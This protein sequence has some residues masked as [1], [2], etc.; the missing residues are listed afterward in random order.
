[1][2]AFRGR[3]VTRDVYRSV[4][5]STRS[6]DCDLAWLVIFFAPGVLPAGGACFVPFLFELIGGPWQNP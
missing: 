2:Q 6:P 1:M 4:L 3:T 5:C